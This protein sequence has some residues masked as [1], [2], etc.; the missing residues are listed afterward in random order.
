M[1]RAPG[2]QEAPPLLRTRR[3]R[4]GSPRVPVVC[5]ACAQVVRGAYSWRI[6]SRREPTRGAGVGA[7]RQQDSIVA[8]SASHHSRQAKPRRAAVGRVA[9]GEVVSH[10]GAD[11]LTGTLA[12]VEGR[13]GL[14]GKP[15][16]PAHSDHYRANEQNSCTGRP[17]APDDSP[18]TLPHLPAVPIV[19]GSW[20]SARGRIG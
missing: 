18:A 14:A 20:T 15:P 19:L 3:A 2:D 4:E 16:S 9:V 7:V 5:V 8:G 10:L 1:G 12:Y 13:R 6:A 11:P 17:D